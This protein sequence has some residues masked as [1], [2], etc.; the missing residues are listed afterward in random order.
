MARYIPAFVTRSWVVALGAGAGAAFVAYGVR[1]WRAPSVPWPRGL[2]AV[3]DE[4]VDALRQ[5]GPVGSRPI[6]VAA[7]REGTIELTGA[8][9]T[10]EEAK[11]A[12]A[13]VHALQGIHT[14]VN[15][16]TVGEEEVKLAEN[17]RRHDEGDPA[18]T[19]SQ[20]EG[21]GVGMGR[22]RQ[23]RDTDPFRRDDRATML[24]RA[25]DEV[26]EDAGDIEA[27]GTEATLEE[28]ERARRARRGASP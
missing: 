17:R 23:S 5:V 19:E 18:L 9:H 6:D 11:R 3:E 27:T 21:M 24:D 26:A 12:V 4:A 20:W 25:I 10:D 15:R 16:L 8:V 13:V 14:V 28:L 7:L 1:R 2:D 22:R